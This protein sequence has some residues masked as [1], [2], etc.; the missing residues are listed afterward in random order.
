M[1]ITEANAV[2]T[3]LGVLSEQ[4]DQPLTTQEVEAVEL[5][6]DKASKALQVNVRPGIEGWSRLVWDGRS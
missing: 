4:A 1:T 5:L 2:V 6:A 3:V